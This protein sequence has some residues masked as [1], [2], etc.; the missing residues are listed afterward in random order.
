VVPARADGDPVAIAADLDRSRLVLATASPSLPDRL[1]P[2][3]HSVP[4]AFRARLWYHPA[5]TDTQSVSAL[6]SC[7]VERM[8][9]SPRPSWPSALLPQ[10]HRLPSLM[11]PREW[12]NPAATVFHASTPTCPGLFAGFN[13]PGCA[14]AT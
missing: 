8:T 1:L 10:A 12:L 11:T 13:R 9:V 5:A 2:H 4:S 14:R 7:G 3:A 6:T